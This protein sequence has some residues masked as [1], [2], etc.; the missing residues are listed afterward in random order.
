MSVLQSKKDTKWKPVRQ[1][2]TAEQRKNEELHGRSA[3][4]YGTGKKQDGTLMANNADWR[5]LQQTHVNAVSSS[6]ADLGASVN[7]R[8]KKFENLSSNIFG[9]QD[10]D[11]QAV[12]DPTVEKA[13][14][15]T[16]ANW[17]A[18]AGTAKVINKGYK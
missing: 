3:T 16:D 13:G 15:G 4:I 8:S 11:N 7:S 6:N 1:Q 9:Q 18:Q 10:K 2:K 12:Y 14:F 17:T 5:N